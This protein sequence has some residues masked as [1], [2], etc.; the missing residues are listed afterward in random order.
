MPS[1]SPLNPSAL[2]SE[3]RSQSE[4]GL[5]SEDRLQSERGYTLVEVAVAI[6]VSFI[7]VGLVY[8]TYLMA[9][10]LT[11][12]WHDGLRLDNALHQT[13]VQFT[14]DVYRA[15]SIAHP[16]AH[17]LRLVTSQRNSSYRDTNQRDT[18]QRD[19]TVYHWSPDD[20]LRRNGRSLLSGTLPIEQVAFSITE[21]TT[22]ITDGRGTGVAQVSL[23]LTRLEE[24]QS[25]ESRV[26][27]RRQPPSWTI[28][29]RTRNVLAWHHGASA[30]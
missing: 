6:G 26:E 16:D 1:P 12:Q 13:G 23:I 11:E 24:P 4:D 17:T 21:R 22:D 14:R 20:G 30:D 2:A 5:R 3:D 7:V 19:T 29:A 18:S 8:S 27:E 9:S 15:R 28:E 10:R 25:E